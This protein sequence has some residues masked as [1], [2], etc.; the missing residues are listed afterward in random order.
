M[1]P[2]APGNPVIGL[3]FSLF[4]EKRKGKEGYSTYR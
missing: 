2:A 1:D 4:K 3:G